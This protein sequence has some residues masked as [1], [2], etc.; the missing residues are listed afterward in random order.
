MNKCT[1]CG[2]ENPEGAA[3]CGK[4]GADLGKTEIFSDVGQPK[5]QETAQTESTESTERELIQA[6][7][8]MG[9]APSADPAVS[10]GVLGAA[11]AGKRLF[12][13]LG[14][15]GLAGIC[16]A[17]GAVGRQL[18]PAAVRTAVLNVHHDTGGGAAAVCYDSQGYTDIGTI[19]VA[20]PQGKI[21]DTINQV[22]EDCYQ[23]IAPY[24]SLVYLDSRNDLYVKTVGE[25]AVRLAQQADW[26]SLN[27]KVSDDGRLLVWQAPSGED[28]KVIYD[29][30]DG[31]EMAK[32]EMGELMPYYDA[33]SG[34]LY[35][36]NQD[37][38]L[39]AIDDSGETER[40]K[41]D[42]SGFQVQDG[43]IFCN[44]S[45]GEKSYVIGEETEISLGGYI[46]SACTLWDGNQ[47][48]VLLADGQ[49]KDQQLVMCVPGLEPAVL[50]RGPLT[51]WK[52]SPVAVDDTMEYMVCAKASDSVYYIRN[53]SLYRLPIPKLDEKALSDQQLFEKA[54]DGN[55]EKLASGLRQSTGTGKDGDVEE[56]L[57]FRCSPNGE[58]LAWINVKGE[59]EF[60]CQ[61]LDGGRKGRDEVLEPLRIDRGVQDFWVGDHSLVYVTEGWELK[62][63]SLDPGVLPKD[64]EAMVTLYTID[65][66]RQNRSAAEGGQEPGSHDSDSRGF[67]AGTSTYGDYAAVADPSIGILQVFGDENQ[68]IT[69]EPH[70]E[71]RDRVDLW[72]GVVWEKKLAL[73]D[74]AGYYS[75]EMMGSE[76]FME[77]NSQG[78]WSILDMG[79]G[80]GMKGDFTWEEKNSYSLEMAV[81]WSSW[82]F[83]GMA[84]DWEEARD[85]LEE[86]AG[87]ML[88]ILGMP[89]PK[90]EESAMEY[91]LDLTEKGAVSLEGYKIEET[92]FQELAAAFQFIVEF[93]EY[94]DRMR[95][96]PHESGRM[97]IRDGGSVWWIRETDGQETK[98]QFTRVTAGEV[99]YARKV[100][101]R[102]SQG[103]EERREYINQEQERIR[104]EKRRQEE[105]RKRQEEEQ[106]R[107]E[108]QQALT[109]RARSY[110]NNGVYL[111]KGTRLYTSPNL[112]YP[113]SSTTSKNETWDVYDYQV[114]VSANRIW[115]KLKN[116]RNQYLWV[117]R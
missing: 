65:E 45:S 69:L 54:A 30:T 88:E 112:S 81:D 104:E 85:F 61:P 42:I 5:E 89:C 28:M 116:S 11:G 4:C 106:R 83:E 94:L 60:Y 64:T 70:M 6:A 24:Q 47:Y 53:N 75:Y 117:Y 59:L 48:L 96:D 1:N 102:Q 93:Q 12:K 37:S 43:V 49:T 20:G 52:S 51:G 113:A 32:L 107:Q 34:T 108:Q 18:V 27:P 8:E 13:A 23:W 103:V 63:L 3:F 66:E 95:E 115:L 44:T 100:S 97:E 92:D 77:I 98:V 55:K 22:K 15:L 41:G 2:F 101:E 87:G 80:Q 36:V 9:P 78:Q 21:L 57:L 46:Q 86:V 50:E 62:K 74:I 73:E 19:T 29:L 90:E 79:G 38:A 68:A 82:D 26:L 33:G 99:A 109:T 84:D 10:K 31:K 72:D 71:V 56:T 114:D 14:V 7:S 40:I 16:F 67:W 17:A 76:I 91:L 111:S 58:N 35:Y 110:Y 25:E 105:E 39:L